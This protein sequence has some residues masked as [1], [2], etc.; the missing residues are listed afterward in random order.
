LKPLTIVCSESLL[1]DALEHRREDFGSEADRSGQR[2]AGVVRRVGQHRHRDR[3]PQ[4]ERDR[5]HGFPRHQ[6]VA[7]VDVLRATVFG[8]AGI[9]E[10][11]RL[12]GGERGLHFR[13]GHHLELDIM[14]RGALP[15]GLPD[16]RSRAP[17]RRRA[18]CAWLTRCRSF[19]DAGQRR[20]IG[21][22]C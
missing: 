3:V 13:P 4:P 22:R 21:E 16:T 1:G 2:R 5:L 20:P 10:R 18:P 8:P 12:P 17:L 7:A 11:R 9:D 14:T 15:L 19:A 6:V